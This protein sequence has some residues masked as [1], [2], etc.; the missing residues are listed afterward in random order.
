MY[1]PF[2]QTFQGLFLESLID[3][4]HSYFEQKKLNK[5]Y[6]SKQVYLHYDIRS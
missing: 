1:S 5:T 6:I 4:S 3:L 2:V